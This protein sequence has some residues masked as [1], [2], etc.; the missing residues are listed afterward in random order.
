ME[1]ILGLGEG[2]RGLG[3]SG[4]RSRIVPAG[5]G[6]ARL[7]RAEE[8]LNCCLKQAPVPSLCL[9]QMAI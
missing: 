8:E 7:E 4:L 1:C 2:F 5:V 6:G 3:R 9:V